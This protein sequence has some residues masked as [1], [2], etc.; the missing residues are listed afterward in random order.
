MRR[1]ILSY[2]VGHATHQNSATSL[3]ANGRDSEIAASVAEP[4]K[5]N[6]SAKDSAMLVTRQN[7]VSERVFL[8]NI[9]RAAR[10][11]GWKIAHFRPALTKDGWRTAVQGDGKGW[12]DCVLVHRRKKRLLVAELK[13]ATAQLTDQQQEWL[14]DFRALP[15]AEVFVWRPA[16]FDKAW[17]ILSQ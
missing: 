7:S 5:K 13:S 10:I 15:F 9:I 2:R 11:C 3:H 12:P 8:G 14:D 16:D 1:R 6:T 17:E 4:K